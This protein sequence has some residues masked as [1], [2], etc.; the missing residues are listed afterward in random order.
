MDR[1][2]AEGS[3]G[4]SVL[5]AMQADDAGLARLRSISGP[6]VDCMDI[7]WLPPDTELP[8]ELIRDRTALIADSVP[9]N[10]SAMRRL[11]WMQI[12]SAGFEHLS[13]LP[14]RTMGI[15][16][17][18]A[19]GTNDGPIA[20]WCLMMMLAFERGLTRSLAAQQRRQWYRDRS[21]QTELR[22]RRVGI[23]GYGNIGRE[24]ARLCR[25]L[26]ME[27][28]AMNRGPIG[29]R[30]DRF[31]PAGTGDPDGVLPQRT[32]GLGQLEQFLPYLDYLVVTA[33][34]T[35]ETRGVL[36]GRALRMLPSSAVVL[37]PARARLLDE[38]AL[39]RALMDGW[40]A[41]AALDSHYREPMPADDPFWDLP[42]T[43]VTP[44]LSGSSQG[45]GYRARLWELFA[46]NLERHIAGKPLLNEIP[47]ADL[48]AT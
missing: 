48:A 3:R 23:F 20:E 34:L 1:A 41:G 13:G 10:L 17:T 44:H 9:R 26:G 16:V 18:N 33:A 19:S 30:R 43:I 22:G 46:A 6:V 28:W 37:N 31:V 47:W 36:D 11:T 4:V 24:T 21:F 5:I 35:H 2:P 15:H 32:F 42:N 14:F 25:A 12:G 39:R 45:A 29:P 38:M 40:I 27:V 8:D 7:E